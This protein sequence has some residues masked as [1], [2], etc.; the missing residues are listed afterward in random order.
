MECYFEAT[1]MT[2]S[3][4]HSRQ[5]VNFARA[6]M[7][8]QALQWFKFLDETQ[9]EES[10]ILD[11]NQFRELLMKRFRPVAA[12]T[13]A[14]AQLHS[15]RQTSSV[16]AYIQEFLSLISSVPNMTEEERIDKFLFGLKGNLKRDIM[17]FDISTLNRCVDLAQKAELNSNSYYS[18]QGIRNSN[19][20]RQTQSNQVQQQQTPLTFHSIQINRT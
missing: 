7:R 5:K 20:A 17:L 13:M 14:R 19:F 9:S 15:L 2:E 6:Q 18:T 3:V 16:S 10:Q 4:E 8:G 1:G 11:W 12:Y